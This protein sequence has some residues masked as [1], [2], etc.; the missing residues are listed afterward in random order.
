MFIA[1]SNFFVYHIHPCNLFQA[2]KLVFCLIR[3]SLLRLFVTC[4]DF[5]SETN[6]ALFLRLDLEKWSLGSW[7]VT[8]AQFVMGVCEHLKLPQLFNSAQDNQNHYH[9]TRTPNELFDKSSFQ[10]YGGYF[11]MVTKL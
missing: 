10:E 3:I 8:V 4:I 7:H 5:M 11:L 9:S 1:A 2:A 6:F